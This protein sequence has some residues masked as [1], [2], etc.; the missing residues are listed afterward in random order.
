M[1]AYLWRCVPYIAVAVVFAVVAVAALKFMPNPD[2]TNL[3]GKKLLC[4][5]SINI[6]LGVT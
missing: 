3:T 2:L 1:L 4:F 5:A 6:I